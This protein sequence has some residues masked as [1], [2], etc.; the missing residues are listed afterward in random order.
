QEP[1]PAYGGDADRERAQE[2]REG[3]AIAQVAAVGRG[4]LGDQV[5]LERPGGG[6]RLSLGE[7]IG[8]RTALV[9][10]ADLRDD[11]EAAGV[12]AALRDLEIRGPPRARAN[13]RRGGERGKHVRRLAEHAW[14]VGRRQAHRV[15][16]P[17]EVSGADE[18]VDLGE[19]VAQ[20]VGVAL[21][22]AAGD[23]EAPAR[24]TG[25][26]A[27][28]LEDRVDRLLL[29]RADEGAR[30]H[31][32]HVRGVGIEDQLVSGARELAEHDLAV[33]LVLRTAQ[34]DEA[35][36]RHGSHA[37]A[38]GLPGDPEVGLTDELHRGLQVVTLLPRH[39][40]LVALDRDLDLELRPL[41]DLDDLARL[42]GGNALLQLD[43]LLGRAHRPGLDRTF[44][45][46][47]ERHLPLGE[48]LLQYLA[49]GPDLEVVGRAQQ[50]RLL[51]ALDG[52][53][54]ALEVEA[55]PD[56]AQGLVDGVVD[57]LEVDLADDVE[58]RHAALPTR[59]VDG[60][61]RRPAAE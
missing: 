49:Q 55:L 26:D 4:I 34:R 46:R 33:D 14:R 40:Q 15:R 39:P 12:V 1:Q 59:R 36:A 20:L 23:D 2:L 9:P 61:R 13:A 3:R 11:A 25:L 45:Q 10:A 37:R 57:L 5:D 31:D 58:G 60:S 8:H 19:F 18:D 28:Q 50:Q 29:G 21:G 56:L 24:P 51:F 16:E 47:L 52:R 48:L 22:E 43:P 54:G 41:H 17:Q 6:Q 53:V 42:V 7:E 38:G 32:Q 30:V 35:D 27:R 44:L